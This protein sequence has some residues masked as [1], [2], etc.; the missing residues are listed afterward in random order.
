M[1]IPGGGEQGKTGDLTLATQRQREGE[2]ASHAISDNPDGAVCS[3]AAGS[4]G[5]GFPASA[6]QAAIQSSNGSGS[7]SS[8]MRAV[9]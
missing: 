4:R 2:Q 6:E 9:R 8:V 7:L 1:K 5:A 3:T